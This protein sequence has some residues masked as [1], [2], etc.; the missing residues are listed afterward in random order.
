MPLLILGRSRAKNKAIF[1][2]LFAQRQ[3]IEK[4][5]GAS[6]DW[7]RLDD[8]RASNIVKSFPGS[9]LASP[10]ETWPDLE[11]Q[12]IGAMI[13]FVEALRPRPAKV[14]YRAALP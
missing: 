4:E 14:Q 3:E 7:Q 11:D 12:M 5:V 10:E 6:L 8:K 9:G 2:T 1:G 13:R